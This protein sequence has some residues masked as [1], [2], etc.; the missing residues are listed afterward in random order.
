[1][2]W[3]GGKRCPAGSCGPGIFLGKA[4][5]VWWQRLEEVLGQGL[6]CPDV[7]RD[8]LGVVPLV[9]VLEQGLQCSNMGQRFNVGDPGA[10]W[11]VVQSQECY[12]GVHHCASN[13][14]TEAVISDL[15]SSFACLLIGEALLTVTLKL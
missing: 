13:C 3:T 7:G 8:V 2:T 9:A 11:H 6:Q 10:V 1:M 12:A 15:N 14:D 5:V 4:C